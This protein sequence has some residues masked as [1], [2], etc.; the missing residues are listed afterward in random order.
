MYYVKNLT[1][2]SFMDNTITNNNNNNKSKKDSSIESNSRDADSP[3]I[4][5]YQLTRVDSKERKIDSFL[6]HSS[7]NESIRNINNNT[8]KSIN[9]A[10]SDENPSFSS[11]ASPSKLKSPLRNQ[12]LEREIN[13]KSVNE[14]KDSIEINASRT[15]RKTLT[16]MNFVGCLDREMSLIQHQTGLFI[17][18]TGILS[19]ELFYQLSVFNFGNF[20][21]FKLMQPIPVAKL[22]HMALD[23]PDTEWTPDDGSKEKLSKRCAKLLLSKASLL[24][25]YFSIKI[26]KIAYK[27]SADVE[28]EE[29]IVLEALPM[30]L[31]DFEPNLIDL[32]MFI[33]R[34]ATEV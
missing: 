21:Y 29:T 25:D 32:P 12:I 1:L 3:I 6:H 2:D 28:E 24:D 27:P 13:F 33:I 20:G 26:R 22:A 5:P 30:L 16:D 7:L 23:D 8:N 10:S 4:Y 19:E 9:K 14:L 11:S 18:N 34:L 15:V 31:E 17:V